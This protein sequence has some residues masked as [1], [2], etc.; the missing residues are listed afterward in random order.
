MRILTPDEFFNRF[1][2]PA[3]WKPLPKGVEV[4]TVNRIATLKEMR[5]LHANLKKAKNADT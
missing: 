2:D 5:E 4:L 3:E 1:G